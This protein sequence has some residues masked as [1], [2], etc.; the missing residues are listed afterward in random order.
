MPLLT[1]YCGPIIEDTVASWS[2]S[3]YGRHR[4]YLNGQR[5][6]S[7]PIL[8]FLASMMIAALFKFSLL[9]TGCGGGVFFN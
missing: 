4:C 2:T 6:N 5:L 7:V 8:S 1:K 3:V 9:L